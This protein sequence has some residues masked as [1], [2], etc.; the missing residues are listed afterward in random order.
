[1][2]VELFYDM[3]AVQL[4]GMGALLLFE[5]EVYCSECREWHNLCEMGVVQLC[6][7]GGVWLFEVLSVWFYDVGGV[8]VYEVGVI[9]FKRRKLYSCLRYEL[10]CFMKCS[11]R[12]V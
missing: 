3:R 4:Y 6:E 1:M 10:C 11:C 9:L 12:D 5:M 7:M 8:H 2:G